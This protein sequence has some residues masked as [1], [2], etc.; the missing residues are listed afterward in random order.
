MIDYD[1]VLVPTDGSEAATAA[2]RHGLAL[3]ATVGA[4][5]HVLSVVDPDRYVTDVVGDVGDL[6]TR[7]RTALEGR[8]RDAVDRAAG[9]A[10]ASVPVETRV[11]EGRPAT[12]LADAIDARGADLVAMGVHGRTGLDRYLLGSLTERTVRTAPVPVLAVRADGPPAGAVDDVLLATDGSAGSDRA[13]EHAT[14]VAD[15]ADATLHA[16]TVGDDDAPARRAADSAR[17]AGVPATVAVRP[18]TPDEA[19]VSYVGERGV[20]LV[21]VG[22]HGRTGVERVLLGSVA[23][24][25]LRTAP[26]PV[27]VVGP[28]S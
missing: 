15:A 21:T 7:Q 10:P 9:D 23:E 22:T 6:V 17:A 13:A 16:L 11:V 8:A 28:E 27:L 4:T 19:I 2:A 26:V 14:A 12:V 3:A 20:D 1:V 18:G 24:R 5:A 25:V